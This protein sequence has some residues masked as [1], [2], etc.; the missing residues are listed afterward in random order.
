MNL[1]FITFVAEAEDWQV[2]ECLGITKWPR[3]FPN[4]L[5]KS[6]LS[7]TSFPHP[8]TWLSG[9]GCTLGSRYI[10]LSVKD[11]QPDRITD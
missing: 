8:K 9:A 1:Y 5:Q 2:A 7:K 4:P 3:I 11:L 10:S 6:V